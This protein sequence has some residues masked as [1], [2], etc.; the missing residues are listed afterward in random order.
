MKLYVARQEGVY[1]HNILIITRNLEKAIRVA[2]E[3]VLGEI[4]HYHHVVV[5]EYETETKMFE[6]DQSARDNYPK[7]NRGIKYTMGTVIKTVSCEKG[8]VK[9]EDKK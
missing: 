3:Y 4:D 6:V 7:V 1:T 8:N 5:E 2:V 9:V